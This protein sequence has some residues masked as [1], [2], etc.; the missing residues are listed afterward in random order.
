[1]SGRESRESILLPVAIPL[2]IMAAIVAVLFLFSRVLLS[3]SHHAATGVALA[4]A[5]SVMGAATFIA[6]RP[7]VTGSLLFSMVA[8]VAGVAMVAGGIAIAAIGP[9]RPEHAQTPPVTVTLS[10]STGAAAKGFDEKALSFPANTPVD[11]AFANHDAGTGHNVYI[12]ASKANASTPLFAGSTVTGPATF[13]YTVHPFAAGTY[14]FFCNI[15]PTTMNGTLTVAP[16]SSGAAGVTVTAR[17]TTFDTNT[18]RLAGGRTNTITFENQDPGTQHNIG[19]YKDAGFTNEL[20]KGELVT[21]PKTATYDVPALDPGTYYF[22][23]DVHP[24]MKG[25]VVVSGSGPAGSP[26]AASSASASPS[27]TP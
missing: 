16:A 6:A 19:I 23:C 8:G 10:A 13:T 18:I 5:V 26:S 1:M 9:N 12:A 25:T 17:N 14:Y 27:A 22:K 24:T 4:V 7:R 15:H 11:L 2:G 21:G 20:F 3:T